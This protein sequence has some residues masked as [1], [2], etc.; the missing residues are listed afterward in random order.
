M[1][2]FWVSKALQHFGHK[3]SALM[4]GEYKIYLRLSYIWMPFNKAQEWGQEKLESALTGA[5][6]EAGGP[7]EQGKGTEKKNHVRT[8]MK[9]LTQVI[10][11]E[12][13]QNKRGT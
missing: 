7:S 8:G 11:G 6:R 12:T 9:H 2:K 3:P 1:R 10:R 4:Y 13:N 5:V